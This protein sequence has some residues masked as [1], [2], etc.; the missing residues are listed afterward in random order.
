MSLR[1]GKPKVS[2]DMVTGAVG[3]E[4]YRAAAK[5]GTYSLVKTTTGNS[6]QNT[7]A[8]AGKTYYYKVVAV[9]ANTAGNSADSS[10]VSIKATK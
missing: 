10:A 8:T 3:Y 6:Y 2:W 5:S 1:S 4:V 9:C 7:G